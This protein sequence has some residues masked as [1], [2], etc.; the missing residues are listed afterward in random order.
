MDF[1]LIILKNLTH[2]SE[3]FGKVMPF[4]KKSYLKETGSQQLFK[5]IKEYYAEYGG[6]PTLTE[7]VAKV[8]SVPNSTIREEIVKTLQA[9]AKKDLIDNVDFLC[10]ETVAW[11]KDALYLEALQI[12]S[13]G[14]M[15]KNDEKKLKAQEILDERSKISIDTDLGLD[16][17]DIE[18]MIAYYK[19]RQIGILTQHKELNKRLGPGFMPRTLSVILAGQGIGKSLLFTDLISGMIKNGKN[20]LLVSLEMQDKEI[21]KRVHANAMDLPINSLI[22]LSKTEGELKKIRAGDSNT[23]GRETITEEMVISAY[24]R[25]KMEG[26]TGKLFIKDYPSGTFS[27]LQLEQLAQSYKIEKG[28]TF[29]AIFI[30][31]LGIM[32]SDRVSPN[33]GLY[34]YIK[35]IGEEVRASASKLDLAI[36]S[37]SQLNRGSLQGDVQDADNSNI[38]DSMGTAM[39]ADFMLFLLQNEEMKANG[40]IIL[41]CTKNRFNGRTDTWAMNIDY[42]HMRFNDVIVQAMSNTETAGLLDIDLTTKSD[43]DD[44]MD[45]IAQAIAQA[46]KMKRYEE[47]ADTEVK[48]IMR[49]SAEQ[50]LNNDVSDVSDIKSEIDQIY[51]DLGI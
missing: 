39:T 26:K 19:E 11:A 10:N 38:S 36:I 8:R 31:Y 47:F 22:D 9:V 5:L 43:L 48:D 1:E 14:L 25:L 2:N 28:I 27:A 29:D 32:K 6:I 50:L 40:E 46:E 44:D 33:A 18:E 34:S 20:V 35:S 41:K 24:N 51:A 21:M 45:P 37:A 16:F 13:E 30:D 42:T 17:D 23:P 49:E 3:Y 15:E 4:L 7:L 12:G